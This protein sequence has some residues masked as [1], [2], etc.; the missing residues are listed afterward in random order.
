MNKKKKHNSYIQRTYIYKIH[1][2]LWIITYTIFNK[3]S[4]YRS[5]KCSFK[6]NKKKNKKLNKNNK[7][8][9]KMNNVVLIAKCINYKKHDAAIRP[10]TWT[11]R[12]FKLYTDFILFFVLN[13]GRRNIIFN[14]I[15]L[16]GRFLIFNY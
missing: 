13:H 14:K 7:R 6:Q 9:E 8:K 2:V 11:A 4:S 16:G 5:P 12:P 3:N 15:L 1:D 10:K